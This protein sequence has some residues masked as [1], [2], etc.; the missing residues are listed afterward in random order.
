[1]RTIYYT[2]IFFNLIAFLSFSQ[3]ELTDTD[4]SVN[5]KNIY[6]KSDT[7]SI[8]PMYAFFDSTIKAY[9]YVEKTAI[10]KEFIAKYDTTKVKLLKH[11]YWKVEFLVKNKPQYILAYYELDLPI[12]KGYQFNSN[13][14]LISTLYR[15]PKIKDSI[16]NGFQEIFYK[17][18]V[19]NSIEYRKFNEDED[20]SFYWYSLRYNK[21]GHL[22]Y[23]SYYDEKNNISKNCSYNK[24]GEI[25]NE[26]FR[27][28]S[29][30]YEKNWLQNRKK[31][32]IVEHNKNGKTIKI[33]RNG[34][35]LKEKV[36]QF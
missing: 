13:N 29:V 35:L 28:P 6:Y 22:T 23:Y 31:V 36:K 21:A 18:G 4:T 10:T 34:I 5:Y 33:Y 24:R 16:Y 30:W 8:R 32:K 26:Y 7:L 14:Q 25:V 20:L 2:T 19:I 9:N 3:H 17:K 12:G 15:Y 11:G 1:M 27:T